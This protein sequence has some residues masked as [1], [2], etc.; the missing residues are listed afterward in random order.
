[1]TVMNNP[2]DDGSSKLLISKQSAPVAEREVCGYDERLL[3]I[4]VSNDAVDVIG[5]FTVYC[6]VTPFINDQQIEMPV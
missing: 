2:V 1:M 6:S 3:F 5:A 4:A